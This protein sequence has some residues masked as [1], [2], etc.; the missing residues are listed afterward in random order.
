MMGALI[1]VQKYVIN[2]LKSMRKS[3]LIH[4]KN[5]GIC[6]ARN[7]GLDAA[8]GEYIGFCDND[9]I[10]LPHLLTDNYRMAVDTG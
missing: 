6:S 4:K 7:A 1:T 3:E 10:Y 2:L 9:D 5:G 8:E